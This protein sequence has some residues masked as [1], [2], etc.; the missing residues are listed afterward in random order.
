MPAEESERGANELTTSNTSRGRN[1]CK[2]SRDSQ[3]NS[4]RRNTPLPTLGIK[5]LKSDDRKIQKE[6]QVFHWRNDDVVLRDE[7]HNAGNPQ[8]THA[9]QTCQAEQATPIRI[10]QRDK[11][12]GE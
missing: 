11:R 7:R 9:H 1:T 12:S 2:A 8:W 4:K 6:G 5:Q 10:G 3:D